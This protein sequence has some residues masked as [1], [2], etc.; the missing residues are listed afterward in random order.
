MGFRKEP[1]G[2][3]RC[4]KCKRSL[5][6]ERDRHSTRFTLKPDGATPND[7]RLEIPRV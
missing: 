7:P 4:R 1:D 2:L 3:Y 6:I 5:L